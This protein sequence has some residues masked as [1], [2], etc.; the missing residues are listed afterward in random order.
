M[1]PGMER[2]TAF[3]DMTKCIQEVRI[4]HV[5]R[6]CHWGFPRSDSVQF[7]AKSGSVV[8]SV[9]ARDVVCGHHRWLGVLM[10]HPPYSFHM[11]VRLLEKQF[12][13][14]GANQV[15]SLV[16]GFSEVNG[17]LARTRAFPRVEGRERH[18]AEYRRG[19]PGSSS[20]RDAER[21]RARL[22]R[23]LHGMRCTE[24]LGDVCHASSLC[25]RSSGGWP[26][27]SATRSTG[28]SRL[29]RGRRQ[30]GMSSWT[31]RSCTRHGDGSNDW[32][33]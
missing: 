10:R 22:L 33:A 25:G 12:R 7:P 14:K 6:W 27:M 13:Y 21:S 8:V 2:A 15:V 30:Y 19:C 9:I 26:R 18:R 3:L 29:W 23:G 24:G 16:H 4:W 32:W 31:T 11:A 17:G 20:T 1:R 5:W 28:S